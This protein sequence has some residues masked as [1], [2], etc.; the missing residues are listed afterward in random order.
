MTHATPAALYAH[1]PSR[2]WEDD[3]KVPAAA[4]RSCK[5]IALQL[6]EEEPGR[7]INVS[8]NFDHIIRPTYEEINTC[9]K[10]SRKKM[11]RKINLNTSEFYQLGQ[12]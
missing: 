12:Y 11:N 10:I 9:N 7:S 1:S 5:D 4:R 3:G 2:Y 6:L 8:I